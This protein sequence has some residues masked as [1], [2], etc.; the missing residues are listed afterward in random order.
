LLFPPVLY[1]EFLVSPTSQSSLPLSSDP[2]HLTFSFTKSLSRKSFGEQPHQ[3]TTC[4]YW[5]RQP[6]FRFQLVTRRLVLTNV[7]QNG[8]FLNTVWKKD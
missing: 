6:S 2:S 3:S 8:P 4:L 7:P 1:P 5:Q